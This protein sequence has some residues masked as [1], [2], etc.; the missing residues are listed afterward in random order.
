MKTNLNK[1]YTA[2]V[3]SYLVFAA[4]QTLNIYTE[5][6]WTGSKCGYFKSCISQLWWGKNFPLP[7]TFWHAAVE[8]TGTKAVVREI[9]LHVPWPFC[10]LSSYLWT[11]FPSTVK[12]TNSTETAVNVWGTPSPSGH[13]GCYL[14]QETFCDSSSLMSSLLPQG[15]P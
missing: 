6:N 10:I 7:W 11:N 3:S 12:L 9:P 13:P 14:L 1:S 2:C 8:V 4:L 5:N 15:E